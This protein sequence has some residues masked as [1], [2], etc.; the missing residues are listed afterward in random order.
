[1]CA[2]F[3]ICWK[4]LFS[5]NLSRSGLSWLAVFHHKPSQEHSGVP[6]LLAV[7]EGMVLHKRFKVF[8]SARQSRALSRLRF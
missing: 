6:F 3:E 7:D 5:G 1:M 4:I 8:E 2:Y